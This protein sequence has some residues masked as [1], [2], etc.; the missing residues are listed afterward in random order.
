MIQ[1]AEAA[2]TSATDVFAFDPCQKQQQ[3]FWQRQ[4]GFLVIFNIMEGDG[5]PALPLY[6]D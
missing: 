3:V 2:T 4:A 5:S 1:E 6:V